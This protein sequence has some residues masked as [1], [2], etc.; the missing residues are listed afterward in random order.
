MVK[1][2]GLGAVFIAVLATVLVVRHTRADEE[3]G[4]LELVGATVVGRQAALTAALLAALVMCVLLGLLTALGLVASGLPVNGS[5][6]FGVAWASVGVAFAGIAA[7]AA[8]LSSTGRG[9]VSLTAAVLGV[10]YLLRAVG[11]TASAAGPRWLTWLSPIGWGQQ[12]RPYAGNRWW[13]LVVTLAFAAAVVATAYVLVARRDLGAGLLPPRLGPA[14]ATPALRSPWALAWRLQR[15]TL[16]GWVVGFV[17]LGLVFGNLATS[18]GDLLNSPRAREFILKLGGRKGLT[19]AYLAAE[20]S[21]IAVVASAYGVQAAMRSRAEEVAGHVEPVL[22]AAV[23]RA[24]WLLSHT[25]VA[26]LG[27]ALLMVVT[28]LAAGAAYGFRSGDAGNVG[29]VLGAAVAHIPAAW[30]LAGI[31]VAAVGVAP[32]WAAVGWAALV[33]FVVLGQ[34]G[35]LLELPQW[36]MDLSP[37]AHVPRLPGAPYDALPDV[38]LTLVALA[39]VATGVAGIRRRD[40]PVT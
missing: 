40:I 37:F 30:V 35:P 24:R 34:I 21:I 20:L 38:A 4:R 32:R 7:V 25:V 14:R 8:Q 1:L 26:L 33:G 28:G 39:L 2:G 31:V 12:F 36:V 29:R 22:A 9:A 27:T 6:A 19:D 5:F 23:M 16:V 3:A 11:D 10:V 17:V 15:G 18:L 13:V